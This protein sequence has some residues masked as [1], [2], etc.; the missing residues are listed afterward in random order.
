MDGM[1]GLLQE[2]SPDT[3]PT[4]SFRGRVWRQA[5]ADTPV[6]EQLSRLTHPLAARVAASR[7]GVG[8][9]PGDW[10]DPKVAR[11]LP[12]PFRF[13]GMAEAARRIAEAVTRKERVAVWTDYD[14]DGATSAAV[15]IRFLRGLGLDPALHVPDRMTEGYGPNVVGLDALHEAGNTLVLILDSGTTAFEPLAAA[16]RRGLD[17]VVIDHHAARD[18]LPAAVAV[19]N[20]NRK[21]EDGAYSYLCAA[22]LTLV[23]CVAVR[24]VLKAKGFFDGVQPPDLMTLLDLVALGTVADVVPLVGLNRAYV[25]SGLRI[26]GRRANVGLTALMAKSGLTTAPE[27]WHCG[28]LLGPRV[29]AGGRVGEASTG[30]RLL[31]SDD[32]QESA[33]LAAR[34]DAWNTERRAIEARC[35]E[36]AKAQIEALGDAL[37]QV[38]MVVG[39]DWHEGVIGIVAGRLKELYNRPVFAFTRVEDGHL[40]ASGRSMRGFDMGRSVIRAHTAGLLVK[41]GGHPMAAGLTIEP[42]RLPAFTLFMEDEARASD[43][44]SYGPVSEWDAEIGLAD[45]TLGTLD[46]LSVLEPHGQANPGP[47]FFVQGVKVKKVE[48]VKAEHLRVT[49]D[50][51]TGWGRKAMVFRAA[52]SPLGDGLRGSEGLYVDLIVSLARNEWQ[53]KVS[54]DVR[55]DDARPAAQRKTLL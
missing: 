43:L 16:A 55:I 14:V 15:M 3:G 39:E 35:V 9:A 10:L 53:G 34:L 52:D 27:A 5:D 36:E 21:D 29:N 8:A 32:P 13:K 7:E 42:E 20:P 22:E 19:V 50:D 41:G 25:R 30:A 28:F 51:G 4:P 17:V 11:L 23:V 37:P 54:C 44:A 33:E 12:D 1:L 45:A 49:L 24:G 6:L 47:R 46:A 18:D 40:K 48:E 26:M 2:R 31:S 38:L